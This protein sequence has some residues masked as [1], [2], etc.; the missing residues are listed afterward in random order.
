MRMKTY[1][2]ELKDFEKQKKNQR[3]GNRVHSLHTNQLT[4]VTLTEP[5]VRRDAKKLKKMQHAKRLVSA[6]TAKMD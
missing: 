4:E 1:E 3:L 2:S 5:T 6:F